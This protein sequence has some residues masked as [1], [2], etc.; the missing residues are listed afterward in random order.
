LD[1]DLLLK[2]RHPSAKEAA[3]VAKK[4]GRIVRQDKQSRMFFVELKKGMSAGAATKALTHQTGVVDVLPGTALYVDRSSLKSVDDHLRYLDDSATTENR[5]AKGTDFYEALRDYLQRHVGADGKIDPTA[6]SR[7]MVHRDNM[8]VAPRSFVTSGNWSFIGPNGLGIPYQ[9]YYGTAPLAGRISA[10]AYDPTNNNSIWVG[11][12]GG[13]LWHSTD[14]GTTWTPLSD[15]WKT[16]DV[17]SIAIDPTNHNNIYVGTGDFDGFYKGYNLG[18]MRSTDGGATFNATGFANFGQYAISKIVVDPTSP[19]VVILTA[20]N[21]VGASAFSGGIWRSTDSGQTWTQASPPGDPYSAL[22]VTKPDT[23]GKVTIWAAGTPSTGTGIYRSTDHGATWTQI[24]DPVGPPASTVGLAASAVDPT[25]VYLLDTGAQAIYSTT[26]AGA[27]WTK[28]SATFPNGNGTLGVNYNWSQSSYDYFIGTAKASP[29][30]DAVFVGLITVV[31]TING[32]STWV[33]YGH[34]YTATALAHNDQHIFVA[35]ADGTQG[36][37]GNDGG[38]FRLTFTNFTNN[39]IPLTS[40]NAHL[41]ITQFYAMAAHPTNATKILGG[42]QDEAS[43]SSQGNLASWPNLFGGDGGWCTFEPTNTY[44]YTTANGSVDQYDF[45]GNYLGQIHDSFAQPTGFITPIASSNDGTKL[46][47]CNSFLNTYNVSAATWAVSAQSLAANGGFVTCIGTTPGDNNRLY[48][49]ANSASI[50]MTTNLGTT[51]KELDRPPLPSASVGRVLPF[52]DSENKVLAAFQGTG[53][54]HL[55]LCSNVLATTPVWTS[56]SG[57]GATAL[58][59]V[60]ANAIV[61]DPYT[62]ETTWYVGTDIGVFMTSNGGSTWQNMSNVLGLPNVQVFDLQK[63]A[64]YLYAGTFGRGIWRIALVAQ[65]SGSPIKSI[66]APSTFYGGNGATGTVTLTAPAPASQTITLTSSNTAAASVPASI[67]I[68]ATAS[69]NTFVV[70]SHG[71]ATS[72]AVT[73]TATSGTS[74]Q[75]THI[76]VVPAPLYFLGSS[77]STVTAG[78][79]L[80][81]TVKI[82]GLAAP[83]GTSVTLSSNNAAAASV[84]ASALI[85]ANTSAANFAI[86]SHAVAS[87]QVVTVTATLGT[88]VKT[89][90]V[91]VNPVVKL[92]VPSAFYAGNAGTGTITLP[93][94]APAGGKVVSISSNNAAAASTAVSSVTIPAGSTSGTFSIVSHPSSTS[95]VVVTFTATASG[96]NPATASTTVMPAPL[97]SVTSSASSVTAGNSLTGTATIAGLAPTGGAVVTL[98]SNDPDVTVPA[99]A[100]IAANG[101]HV[102]FAIHT[103]VNAGGPVTISATYRGVTKTVTITVN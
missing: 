81:G 14:G 53:T 24:A 83:G 86:T 16:I 20:G 36:L 49:G 29:T 34:T 13:G 51:W 37:L 31:Y 15:R 42:A 11:S 102:A 85:P 67:T 4:V 41:G 75:T 25:K 2:L 10:A 88:V 47:A 87:Q 54:P 45:S 82:A 90:A 79:I 3:K 21:G 23:Q 9:Q 28:I 7:G 91:T 103:T 98:S 64:G 63:G 95:N 84:P 43:P 1:N 26:S 71:V 48:F 40:L 50:W 72:T 19:N 99:N 57:T 74:T 8:P 80:T 32:G 66:T 22:T 27:P 69:S 55:Y 12:G 70:T 39:T 30:T 52:P 6:M 100:T 58:P 92:T 59:D 44:Q 96:F 62:P 46:F 78:G 94:A 17:S 35:S 73:L 76:T 18:V 93:A 5:E 61:F 38:I 89:V 101:Y 60:P 77:A 56:V 68:G 33:D 65:A 97:Y